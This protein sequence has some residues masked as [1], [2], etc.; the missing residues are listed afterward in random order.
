MAH[1]LPFS[2]SDLEVT[3]NDI[4]FECE[5]CMNILL[6]DRAGAGLEIVCPH[7]GKDITIPTPEGDGK[8]ADGDAAVPPEDKKYEFDFSGQSDGELMERRDVVAAK[9]KENASQR[10]EMQGNINQLTIQMHRSRL[11]LDRLV[12]KQREFEAELKAL[13]EH[14]G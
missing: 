8:G 12:A 14:L 4:Q 9:L 11:K 6:V 2:K 1:Q 5:H 13:A 3:E 7:C 10:T